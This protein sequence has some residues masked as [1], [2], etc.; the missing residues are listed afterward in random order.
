VSVAS[1]A[2]SS[3][4]TVATVRLVAAEAPRYVRSTSGSLDPGSGSRSAYLRP[5]WSAGS[6]GT[7]LVPGVVAGSGSAATVAALLLDPLVPGSGKP[8]PNTGCP[9]RG[10]CPAQV[11]VQV[12]ASSFLA[13]STREA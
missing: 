4:E 9:L 1:R 5:S 7:P 10:L 11:V 2:A 3:A 12:A 6:T 8:L 13:L